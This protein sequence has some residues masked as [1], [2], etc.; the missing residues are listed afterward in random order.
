M[1][2]RLHPIRFVS[3][4]N[5]SSE[6]ELSLPP[7]N[8]LSSSLRRV[9]KES[10][11]ARKSLAARPIHDLR[12][13]LRR[14]RS[15]AEGFAEIDPSVEWRHMAKVCKRLQ[16][17]LAPLRDV[18]VMSGWVGRFQF[19]IGP[20]GASLVDLLA[21]EERRARHQARAALAEFPRKRWKRWRR[22]LPHRAEGLPSSEPYFATLALRRLKDVR[23]MELRLRRTGTRIAYHR[24]R[25]ALKRFRYTL[26]S[27]LPA[28]HDTWGPALKRLQGLLG[29]IH[30]LDVLRAT[31]QK[32]G[33]KQSLPA[34]QPQKWLARIE[35]E[36]AGRVKGYEKQ[37]VRAPRK[38]RRNAPTKFLWDRWGKQ[39]QSLAVISLPDSA[40][41]LTLAATPA[42]PGVA[43]A[44]PPPG[45]QRRLSSAR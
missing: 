30:D 8:A 17:G 22:D 23:E 7:L 15:F 6:T 26:E 39:L 2:A 5:S 44:F 19:D 9:L 20:G 11:R 1:S 21:R 29:E 10:K 31:I 12:V 14:S 32:L 28:K 42:G 4:D 13:A 40:E 37:I 33:H 43:K 3:G 45:R 24:L 36:R 34:Q 18:Q 38:R 35:R 25:V 16:N 27:F 41:L